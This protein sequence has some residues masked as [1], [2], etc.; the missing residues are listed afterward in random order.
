MVITHLLIGDVGWLKNYLYTGG[1]GGGGVDVS[2]T[3]GIVLQ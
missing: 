1:G 2:N 3:V